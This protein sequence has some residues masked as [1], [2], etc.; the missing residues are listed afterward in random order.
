MGKTT[1]Q[2]D[3]LVSLVTTAEIDGWD[4]ANS[5]A[6][7]FTVGQVLEM[8]NLESLSSSNMRLRNSSNSNAGGSRNLLFGYQIIKG[9]GDYNAIFGANHAPIGS[10]NLIGGASHST[11]CDFSL[12]GGE[13]HSFDAAADWS[14][15]AGLN[16]Q[17]ANMLTQAWGQ[18]AQPLKV[19][20]TAWSSKMFDACGDNQ[21]TLVHMQGKTLGVA[22]VE[23]LIAGDDCFIT[24]D[25]VWGFT[26]HVMGIQESGTPGGT[27]EASYRILRGLIKNV[28]GTVSLV[29]SVDETIIAE[30]T[31]AIPWTYDFTADDTNKKLKLVATMQAGQV[32]KYSAHIF[33]SQAG[34]GDFGAA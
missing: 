27:G 13:G 21:L 20:E 29:G 23:M 19:A 16:H 22:P 34:H 7:R 11:S 25:A 10:G 3:L 6:V 9:S 17:L 24:T 8:D 33:I 2:L 18:D 32:V 30:D 12:M 14:V 28:G 26:A 1:H 5:K 4:V 31:N 15:A